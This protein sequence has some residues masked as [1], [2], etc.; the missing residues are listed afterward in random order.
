[1]HAGWILGISCLP[2][3][4]LISRIHMKSAFRGSSNASPS[5]FLVSLPRSMSSRLY[6][7]IREA[8]HLDEPSWTTDGEI[9]NVDRFVFVSG[10]QNDFGRKFTVDK[11]QPGEFRQMTHFLDQIVRPTGFMYKD[12]VQPFVMAQWLK[13]SAILALIIKRPLADV[14]YAMTGRGWYYPAKMFPDIA[15]KELALIKGL[16]CAASALDLISGQC[17]DFDEL[18]FSEAAVYNALTPFYPKVKGRRIHYI[19]G[20]FE[21]ERT[22]VLARRKT[23]KYKAILEMLATVERT[24]D[25]DLKRGA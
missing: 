17:I 18:I 22:K 2:A 3:R 9:L 16:A 13:T 5:L 10:P 8:L 20:E 1:M 4:M 24:T 11:A 25:K 19:D 14:V 7:A 12:T 6:H 15:N 23:G 21:Q